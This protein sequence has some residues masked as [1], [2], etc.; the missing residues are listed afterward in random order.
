MRI[1]IF[2]THSFV[3]A[4]FT[5]ANER[6]GFDLTFFEPR[7]TEATAGLAVEFPVVCSFVNDRLDAEA[8]AVLHGGGVR[9]IAL[10]SAG[11]NHVDLHAAADLGFPVVRVPEYSPYAV[12]EHAVALI[13]TLNRKIQ[14][15]VNP[16]TGGECLV[17]RT[18][19][20]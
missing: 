15:A 19:W 16:S 4:A 7:L 5:A 20:V 17:G 13:L 11:Y 1:G 3:R 2:D 6:Y 18:R 10:R 9:L 14:R 8:L 12:A